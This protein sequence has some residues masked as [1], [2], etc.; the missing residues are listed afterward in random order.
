MV[1][2]YTKNNIY[3]LQLQRCIPSLLT[4]FENRTGLF[5]YPSLNQVPAAIVH[6]V[7]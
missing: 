4:S 6:M 2:E 5:T 7:G 3:A 1:M